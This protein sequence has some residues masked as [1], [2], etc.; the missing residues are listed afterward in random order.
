M[1]MHFDWHGGPIT[2]A[3]LVDSAYR[4]TQNVRRFLSVECGPDFR[5][6]RDF[7]AW[8]TNGTRKSMGEVADEWSRRNQTR[9]A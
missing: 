4:N 2:R 8:I 9:R 3:T 1:R 7:M 5:F 6:D